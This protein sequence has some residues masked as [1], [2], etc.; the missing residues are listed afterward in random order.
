MLVPQ[1]LG[2]VGSPLLPGRWLPHCQVASASAESKPQ[3]RQA[4]PD[5]LPCGAGSVAVNGTKP[6]P[7]ATTPVVWPLPD[8]RKGVGVELA[9]G[10]H[11]WV[12]PAEAVRGVGVL[13]CPV[14]VFGVASYV[15]LSSA[16]FDSRLKPLASDSSPYRATVKT[17]G[18][19]PPMT[20]R[21]PPRAL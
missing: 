18:L 19:V 9:V 15:T 5:G 13:V 16:L 7:P 21:R 4:S 10:S 20:D 12:V 2:D 8:G 3:R 17:L 14:G 11:G 6:L 1:C